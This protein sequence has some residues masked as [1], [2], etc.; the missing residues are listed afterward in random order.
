MGGGAH[1]N[2]AKFPVESCTGTAIPRL[3][4]GNG[5]NFTAAT[6]QGWGVSSL[7]FRGNG[8][9]CGGNTAVNILF[10]TISCT[11]TVDIFISRPIY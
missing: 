2:A 11:L 4:H 8:D 1:R 9:S 3:P 5:D 7:Y 10:L 6:P